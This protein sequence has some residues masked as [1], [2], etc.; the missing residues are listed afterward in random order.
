V[1]KWAELLE[2]QGHKIVVSKYEHEGI[3]YAVSIECETCWQVLEN[4]DLKE[5]SK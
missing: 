5:V 1:S 4:Y 2:H 3:T